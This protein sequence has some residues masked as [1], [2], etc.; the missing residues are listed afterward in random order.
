M[1]AA[2]PPFEPQALSSDDPRARG[3]SGSGMPSILARLRQCRAQ[4]PAP[5]RGS[6]FSRDTG[7]TGHTQAPDWSVLGDL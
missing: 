6:D 4:T 1:T 5:F 3:H 2:D 7:D